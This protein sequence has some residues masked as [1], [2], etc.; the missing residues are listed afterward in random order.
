[1]EAQSN[2]TPKI[3]LLGASFETGNLGVSALAESSIKVII[4]RWPD[5]EITI[6]GSGYVPRQH[7]LFLMGKEVSIRTLPVRFSKNIF[8]PHHFMRFV[9]FG[10]VAKMLPRLRPKDALVTRN[11]YVKTLFEADLVLDI[12]GG[13]SFSDIYGMRRFVLGFLLKG[14]VKIFRKKLVLLPQT[15]GPFSKRVAKV[16]ARYILNYATIIYSRD[17][18]GVDYVKRLLNTHNM[19]GKIKFLPDLGFILD[20]HRPESADVNS[21][22]EIRT[23]DRVLVGLNISGLLVRGGYFDDDMFNLKVDYSSLVNSIVELLMKYDNTTVLLV[24]HVSPSPKFETLS[25]VTACTKVYERVVD[26]YKGRIFQ[27]CGH[28]NHNQVKYIIGLC[29][30]FIGSRMH[31]CIAALSQCIPAIG[32]AYSKKF[33]G[34]FESVDAGNLVV[35][36]RHFGN[37]ETL[38][39]IEKTFQQRSQVKERLVNTIPGVQDKVLNLFDD[40]ESFISIN[41]VER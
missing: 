10:L 3:C 24:P 41:N 39:R 12:T 8:L 38:Q 6:F 26:K 5:A 28:Y 9:L 19:D 30:F 31:S 14:L 33:D 22:E 7:R 25:D 23:Q 27:I 4:N 17:R 20:S 18:K 16:L 11:P 36:M 1:M 15:Y 21:L 13:D 34:V 32:L 35:D 2:K 40:I 29:D 37:D